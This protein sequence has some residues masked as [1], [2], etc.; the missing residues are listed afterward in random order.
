MPNLKF[1]L[2]I[3]TYNDGPMLR[4]LLGLVKN[5]KDIVIVDS[6][7]CGEIET[8]CKEFGARYYFHSFFNQAKQINWALDNLKFNY[9]W[10]LRL[11]TDEIVSELLLVELNEISIK[12][13]PVIGYIDR[14]MFW[15]GRLLRYSAPRPLYLGRFWKIGF[16]RY[17]EVTE[18]H[19]VHDCEVYYLKNKFYEFNTNNHIQ[20]FLQKHF[21]T[22]LGEL[23]E[24]KGDIRL[25]SGKFFGLRHQRVRWF[26]VYLYN[27]LPLF[28][29]PFFYFIYRYFIRLGFL[30]GAAGF[31][32][33]FFQAFWYRMLVAQL[34]YEDKNSNWFDID[35]KIDFD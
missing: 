29:A 7:S 31:S 26:K 34:M 10:I 8:I 14:Y 19:L 15:M 3:L 11:D 28:W 24:I 25:N 17:E 20:Y 16:A 32:F 22:G 1:S 12:D 23:K 27:H 33:C 13:N 30:D 35:R 2:I 6:G 5:I 21:A 4:R 9:Q 18:E